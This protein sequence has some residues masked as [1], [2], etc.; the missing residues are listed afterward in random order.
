MTRDVL[1]SSSSWFGPGD[2]VGREMGTCE[3]RVIA[4]LCRTAEPLAA[5]AITTAALV[6]RGVCTAPARDL[7][8]W[9]RIGG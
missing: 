1:Y 2:Q 9:T 5:I 6:A 8:S 7:L 4:A 3:L